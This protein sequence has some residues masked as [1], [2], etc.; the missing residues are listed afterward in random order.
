MREVQ[1]QAERASRWLAVIFS[2]TAASVLWFVGAAVFMVAE[3]WTYFESLYFTYT[4]LLTIGYGDY[5][6]ASGSGRAFFVFWSMLAVPTLTILT[7]HMGD[8][9][10]KAFNDVTI[11]IGSMAVLPA[12][13]C[14]RRTFKP[15]KSLL[16]R[17]FLGRRLQPNRASGSQPRIPEKREAQRIKKFDRDNMILDGIIH[18]LEEEKVPQDGKEEE[19]G[20]RW[21]DREVRFYHYLL[22]RELCSVMKD[23]QVVPAKEYSYEEWAWY[24]QLLGHDE[25]ASPQRRPNGND[26]LAPEPGRPQNRAKERESQSWNWLGYNSPLMSSEKEAQWILEGLAMTLEKELRKMQCSEDGMRRQ[27]PPVSIEQC[28]SRRVSKLGEE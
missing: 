20:G 15:S 1:Q 23:I 25:Y 3:G 21:Q 16:V 24:L 13:D 11:W 2:A 9:V 28:K 14:G 26:N 7:S 12:E 19:E 8:T 22:V 4:T 6:P 5:A 17:F 18:N 10:V 27:L